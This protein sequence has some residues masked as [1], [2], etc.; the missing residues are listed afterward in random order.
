MTTSTTTEQTESQRLVYCLY[1]APTDDGSPRKFREFTDGALR[2]ASPAT[3]A[4]YKQRVAEFILCFYTEAAI[5]DIL[6]SLDANEH[7]ELY[8]LAAT[9]IQR[10][11]AHHHD[12]VKVGRWVPDVDAMMMTNATDDELLHRAMVQG[13]GC[14]SDEQIPRA[15]SYFRDIMTAEPDAHRFTGMC[16]AIRVVRAESEVHEWQICREMWAKA[17]AERNA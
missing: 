17:R 4:D 5:D 16:H 2:H 3:V 15:L 13:A 6:E 9:K 12:D 10:Q 8:V 7:D 11:M 14:L 1:E